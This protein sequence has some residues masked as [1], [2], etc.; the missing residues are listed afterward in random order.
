ML[1]LSD[2]LGHCL[3]LALMRTRVRQREEQTHKHETDPTHH[4][5]RALAWHLLPWL[6]VIWVPWMGQQLSHSLGAL[7][8]FPYEWCVAGLGAD[9][10][11]ERVLFQ[12]PWG[13]GVL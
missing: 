5:S 1:N 2:R 3:C 6:G 12:G 9:I 8:A 13:A 10:G 4:G 7:P 11:R